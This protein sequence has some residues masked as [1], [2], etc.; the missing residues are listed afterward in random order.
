MSYPFDSISMQRVPPHRPWKTWTGLT[1]WVVG[2]VVSLYEL[3]PLSRILCGLGAV[4][5]AVGVV[6]ALA[7]LQLIAVRSSVRA[8]GRKF[9]VIPPAAIVAASAYYAA[10]LWPLELGPIWS[11][12]CSIAATVLVVVG[13]RWWMI[14]LTDVVGG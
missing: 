14:E 3:G 4:L 13:W 6:H 9:S 8:R 2:M 7:R 11:F 1:L 5:V 10:S 12:G